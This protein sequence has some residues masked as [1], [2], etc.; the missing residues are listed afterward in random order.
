MWRFAIGRDVCGPAA[1]I[2]LLVPSVDKIGRY[3]PLTFAMPL[4]DPGVTLACVFG[5]YTWYAELEHIALAALSTDFSVEALENTLAENAFSPERVKHSL[6]P[7][8][9]AWLA[10]P[11]AAPFECRFNAVD[12]L[13][14]ATRDSAD[15]LRLSQLDARSV[16]WCVEHLSG[17]TELHCVHRLPDGDRYTRMLRA[18]QSTV[19]AQPLQ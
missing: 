5:S 8:L 1:C 3:F 16:W 9:A 13:S 14:P 4:R 7:E 17:P 15:V 10:A 11:G 12:A 18:A 2:G 19:N 6:S